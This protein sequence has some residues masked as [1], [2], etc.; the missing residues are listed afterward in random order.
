M[1]RKGYAVYHKYR[2]WAVV[3]LGL[4][5]FIVTIDMT[6]VSLALPSIAH[7]FHLADNIASAIS[8]SY[9]VPM[10]LALLPVGLILHRLRPLP[11]FLVSV[12]GFGIGSLICGLS[13]VFWMLM[14]GR[15]IQGVFAAVI[16]TQ[17]IALAATV[18]K[19]SERGRAM[20]VLVT[21]GPLGEMVGPTL[22]GL[23]LSRWHWSII[24]F[25]NLPICLCICVLAL[26]SLRHVVMAG[27]QQSATQEA[28]AGGNP[29]S[30]LLQQ[31][32]FVLALLA[33]LC[34]TTIIG[35][36]YYLVPFNMDDIQH[37]LPAMSGIILFSLPLG[38]FVMGLVGGYLVDRFGVKIPMLAGMILMLVGL[39]T[40]VAAIG[41]PTTGLNI[42]W[43]LLLIGFGSGLF[44][45]P[46]R[47]YLMSVGSRKSMGAASA[48]A[49]VSQNIGVVCGPILV[50]IIWTLFAN[51]GMQM[52]VGIS[53]LAVCAATG[54]LLSW[55][56][57]RKR[58]AEP[59][60][61]S[62]NSTNMVATDFSADVPTK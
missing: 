49:N 30:A 18:V 56:S 47:A 7:A 53:L 27:D 40:L 3:A 8:L 29:M 44:F 13:V 60:L 45:G 26:F 57:T 46:N 16:F 28:P 22:G 2:W 4:S 48:V 38:I 12:L 42:A 34:C 1:T 21:L 39:F 52:V 25:V 61:A 51:P 32:P 55:L 20:G 6:I 17:S 43:R 37:F 10:T 41:Q 24:F 15:I 50:S 33:L 35:G 36:L 9:N 23:L 58:V 14:A 54:L 19:P 59:A 31:A 11:T 62:E 5:L